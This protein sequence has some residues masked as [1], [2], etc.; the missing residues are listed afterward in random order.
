V[1]FFAQRAC[2]AGVRRQ[3]RFAAQEDF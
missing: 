2:A 3:T 1:P